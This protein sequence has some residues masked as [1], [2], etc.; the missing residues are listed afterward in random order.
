MNTSKGQ[1][2]AH[3]LNKIEP[4]REI[5]SSAECQTKNRIR[6][7][8]QRPHDSTIEEKTRDAV[9]VDCT[10]LLIVEKWHRVAG[11]TEDSPAAGAIFV[12]DGRNHLAEIKDGTYLLTKE[13]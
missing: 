8:F 5:P 9:Y 2:L 12:S 13:L 10:G 6:V 4:Q 11:A 7:T 1:T 3:L